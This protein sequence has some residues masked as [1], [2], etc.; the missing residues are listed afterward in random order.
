MC[1]RRH[2][3]L[4]L[5]EETEVSGRGAVE[6]HRDEQPAPLNRWTLVRDVGLFQLKLVMD[7]VR[8]LALVPISLVAG[9]MALLSRGPTPGTEFYDVLRIGRRSERWINLFG[10]ADRARGT[11]DGD[12]PKSDEAEYGGDIDQIANRVESYVVGE[13]KRSGVAQGATDRIGR[14]IRTLLRGDGEKDK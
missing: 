11:A 9:L 6:K 7:G 3:E 14:E 13:F 12:N 8:D 1:G 5:T 4:L 2:G 10:A